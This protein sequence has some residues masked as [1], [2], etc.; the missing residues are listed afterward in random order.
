M[1]S[2]LD[3]FV[4]P[5]LMAPTIATMLMC[6]LAALVGTFAVIKRY[7]L[8]SE[9]L[10]HASYPGVIVGMLIVAD[11]ELWAI[12]IGALVSSVFAMYLVKSMQQ[13]FRVKADAALTFT[14]ASFFGIGILLLTSVQ[15][16]QPALY[17]KMQ[18]YLF[19]QAATMTDTHIWIYAAFAAI[20]LTILFF[21]CRLLT[22]SIFDPDFA[23]VVGL[24]I[25][26]ANWLILSLIIV[27]TIIGCRSVGVVLMS[28]ML[29]FP[30]VIA[31][32]WT[33]NIVPMLIMSGLFGLCFGFFGIYLSHTLS[34]RYDTSFAS[35]PTIVF[36]A[37]LLF[38]IS[39][40][41]SKERGLIV[42]AYRRISFWYR[43]QQENLLK[44]MWKYADTKQITF[45]EI[46]SIFHES[47]VLVSILLYQLK[48]K[49]LV[50]RVDKATYKLTPSGV[51]WA[52][53]IVRLHRLWEVYLVERCGVSKDRVHPSA[54]EMEHIITPEIEEEL[55][56]ILG[57]PQKDPHAQEI[58]PHE[59]VRP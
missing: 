41:F 18:G 50:N 45:Y 44:A 8:V 24:N 19:G 29:I 2:F 20:V 9:M 26:F 32:F 25:Q 22:V 36:V 33:V 37:S 4:D 27:A 42:R 56:A 13:K 53:K 34:L 43:C 39:A 6:S 28:S 55:E 16:S 47:K 58:P 21:Y 1:P 40:L 23:K 3:F 10:S 31:R 46:Q 7:S 12:L 57:H 15:N 17:K 14:L 11:S 49:D 59:Q 35:G 52:R 30:A 38:F 51:V 54:E 48:Q 5:V